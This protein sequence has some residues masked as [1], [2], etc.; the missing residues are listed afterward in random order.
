[1][2]WKCRLIENPELNAF[3]NVDITKRQ[4]GDM[5]YLDVKEDELKDRNLTQHYFKHNAGRK[6][7]VVLLPG[8]Y[9]FLID[10]QCYNEQKGYY[11]AWTVKGVPPLI[12]V[13]PSIN[14]VGRYHGFLRNGV[15][16]DDCDGRKFD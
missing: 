2:S 14:M 10:G 4:V 16:S 13:E 8:R 9:Y 5:W 15:I 3:G 12:S 1:M 11:D 7:L 6:P